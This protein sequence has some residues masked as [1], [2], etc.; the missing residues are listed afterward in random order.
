ME[1]KSLAMRIALQNSSLIGKVALVTGAGRGIGKVIALGF[2]RE[3]A[4]IVAVSRTLAQVEETAREVEALGRRAL[5]IVADIS[6]SND[7]RSI[8]EQVQHSFG[9]LDVLVNNAALR[10]NQLGKKDSYYISFTELT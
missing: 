10:M 5:A 8:A 7:V 6:R 9:G 3:G 4:D 1:S 2:A